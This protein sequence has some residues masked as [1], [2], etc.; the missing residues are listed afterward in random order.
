MRNGHQIATNHKNNIFITD[1]GPFTSSICRDVCVYQ[2]HIQLFC[3]HSRMNTKLVIQ[4]YYTCY[5]YTY[6]FFYYIPTIY[7]EGNIA[8]NSLR[9]VGRHNSVLH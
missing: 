7:E 4:L 5:I 8:E 6:Y 1:N 9:T 2:I 3:K